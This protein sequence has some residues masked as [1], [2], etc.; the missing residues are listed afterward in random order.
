MELPR[1]FENSRWV[2]RRSRVLGVLGVF[3]LFG[4]LQLMACGDGDG[5]SDAES[6]AS[7]GSMTTPTTTPPT[8]VGESETTAGSASSVGTDSSSSDSSSSGPDTES[9]TETMGETTGGSKLPTC[10]GEPCAKLDLL[11]VIDGSGTMAEEQQNLADNFG[12]MFEGLQSIEIGDGEVVPLDLNVM[13]TSADMGHPL[14]D[15]FEPPGYDPAKGSPVS[16]PCTERLDDFVGLMQP[17]LDVTEVC[18]DACPVP[19]APTDP[20]IHFDEDGTNVPG[21]DVASAFG[22]IAPQGIVGCGMEAQLESMLSALD[23]SAQWNG[24][25]GFLR[26][27][28]AL[29]IVLIT[30]EPDCSVSAPEGYTYF[31]PGESANPDVTQFWAL[32]PDTMEKQVTSAVCWNAGTNCVDEDLDGTYESCT[33]VD[34]PVLFDS[35]RYSDYF[36]GLR[37]QDPDR[38]IMMLAIVGVPEVTQYNAEPPNEPQAGGLQELVYRQ[39]R[40]GVYPDGDILPGEETNAATQEFLWGI[41]PGCT[42][43]DNQVFTG[44]AAPPLRVRSVCESLNLPDDPMTPSDESRVRCCIDSICSPDFSRGLGCITGILEQTAQE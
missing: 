20:F 42:G 3:G 33:E 38:I 30:D 14:C 43:V 28:A 41:G 35:T 16:S 26:D 39:W 23:P 37:Q 10:N 32:N 7:T 19:L 36:A 5:T 22:C 11:F 6:T 2:S 25:A 24:Q 29:G 18:M 4:A 9:S 21:D 34:N 13:V 1:N 27:D 40:D 8:T 17:P 31:D 12:V 15:P 44:Q